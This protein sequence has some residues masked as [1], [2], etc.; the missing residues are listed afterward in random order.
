MHGLDT[1]ATQLHR[2][3][4]GHYPAPL[5]GGNVL[6]GETALAVVLVRTGRKVGGMLFGERNEACTSGGV[7]LQCEV[8]HDSPLYLWHC[9]F[10]IKW[11]NAGSMCGVR[12][13]NSRDAETPSCC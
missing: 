7:G 9:V 13:G 4:G 6:E 8:H 12:R 1:Q 5:H 11:P 10:S 2:D 3:T